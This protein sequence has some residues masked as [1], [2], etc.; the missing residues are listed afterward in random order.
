M[1]RNIFIAVV[2]GALT[3]GAL[4]TTVEAASSAPAMKFT[5]YSLTGV[6]QPQGL[7]AAGKY[8]WIT[9]M[10]PR[11]D[12]DSVIRFDAATDGESV[13]KSKYGTFLSQVVASP[14]YAWVLNG[15][16]SNTAS[17]SFLRIKASSLAVQR[18][19]IPAADNPGGI[20][21]DQTPIFLAGNYL[22]MP[23]PFGVLRMD[24]TTLKISLITSPLINGSP[25]GAAVDDHDLWLS[26]PMYLRSD[27]HFFVRVSLATGA[28]TKENFPGVD[29]GPPVGDDGTNLWV[30]NRG[31]LQKIDPATGHVTT[32][33]ISKE[34]SIT[35]PGNATSAAA[36]GALYLLA[37]LPTLGRN[38]VMGID[39]ANG[40][41]AVL[42]SPLLYQP[43]L[44][45]SANRVLWVV[46][47][48]EESSGSASPPILIRVK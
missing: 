48:P 43:K 6:V 39:I 27:E 21:L 45:A 37:D 7:A 19:T 18:I 16:A 41:A 5:G 14:R 31:G 46:N 36:G 25:L 42:S 15:T 9:T 47:F 38:G 20:S 1:R 3:L 33:T 2:V 30:I 32:S 44:V 13:V 8:V 22:W 24:T 4:V 10:G 28:V 40:R 34:T 12:E 17:W 11:S 23:G 29:G 35:L 26:A